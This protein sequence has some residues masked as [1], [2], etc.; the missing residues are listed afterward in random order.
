M[1]DFEPGDTI[2]LDGADAEVIK[3]HSVGEIDCLR[4][5]VESKTRRLSNEW[6]EIPTLCRSSVRRHTTARAKPSGHSSGIS[7]RSARITAMATNPPS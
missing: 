4:A 6:P 5:Y 7:T 3:T 1:N 2:V